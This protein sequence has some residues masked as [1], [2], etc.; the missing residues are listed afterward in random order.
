MYF[1]LC[2]KNAFVDFI[3]IITVFWYLS[4]VSFEPFTVDACGWRTLL[5][6]LCY[7]IFGGVNCTATNL[8]YCTP[9]SSAPGISVQSSPSNPKSLR[10]LRM[11]SGSR[12]DNSSSGIRGYPKCFILLRLL[13]SQFSNMWWGVSSPSLQNLEVPS[14]LRPILLRCSLSLQWPKRN[15][16]KV[17]RLSL[18]RQISCSD[19]LWLKPPRRSFACLSPGNS[20]HFLFLGL[21]S[22]FLR[23]SRR[24]E[25]P[26]P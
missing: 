20:A 14:S 2:L 3:E 17:L 11:F 10:S 19:L 12:D 1:C 21:L 15:P 6:S 8:I 23:I 22:S 26:T 13:A 7:V 5:F 24:Y 25:F 9:L 16:V 4:G 18:L